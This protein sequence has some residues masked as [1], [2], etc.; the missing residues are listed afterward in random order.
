MRFVAGRGT[1]S[2]R[3]ERVL[4]WWVRESGVAGLQSVLGRRAY[5]VGV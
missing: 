2:V 5:R 1:G 3:E 4:L